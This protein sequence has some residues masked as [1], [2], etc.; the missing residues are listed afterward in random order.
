MRHSSGAPT[1]SISTSTTTSYPPPPDRPQLFIG[2]GAPISLPQ[3]H[4]GYGQPLP[5]PQ[6]QVHPYGAAPPPMQQGY[7]PGTPGTPVAHPGFPYPH[8]ANGASS[9]IPMAALPMASAP[10]P[11]TGMFTRN[12]IGSL[13]V[14]AFRLTDTEGKVGFWFVLQDLSVRTEGSFRYVRFLPCSG[15]DG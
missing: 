6:A 9:Y 4:P 2:A 13:T 11:A 8:P 3:Y 5:S 7:Y 15:L 12:L 1:V 14:N 10:A